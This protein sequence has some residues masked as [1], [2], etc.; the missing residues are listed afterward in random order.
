MKDKVISTIVLT[1][2]EEQNI[3]YCLESLRGSTEIF[4]VDSGS[5]DRTI[6]I[7][8]QFN[9]Q[10]FH[11]SYTNHASQWQWAFDNLPISTP[12]ILALDADFVVSPVLLEKIIRETGKVPDDVDGIYVRHLYKFGWGTI[13]FGGTKKHWLRI[14]RR[15]RARADRG[16]LVDFRF[17]VDGRVLVWHEMVV[18]YNR[19]DDDISVWLGKQDKFALR[20]A[21]EE[22]L[23]RRGLH[24]WEGRP[25]LIGTTDERFAWL[26]DR[27]LGLPLFVR[28]IIYFL[29][30]YVIAAGALDGRAGFLYHVL[31]GFW[32]RLIVDWKTV[33]LRSLDLDDE[34]LQ[35]FGRAMLK[36]H[37]GSVIEVQR[38][39]QTSLSCIEGWSAV[40]KTSS[41]RG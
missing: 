17:V 16:D 35:S 10:I 2:N 23:R 24:G 9:V 34:Q 33:Q 20:L 41:Q 15:G 1:H 18:E 32:L 38:S 26:R 4:V 36:T 7:C 12:W 6:D 40:A 37:S 29:Y 13:R 39:I 22:E 11:H 19:K 31:Q 28:P 21:V 3:G 14:V 27:W 5:T 8:K 30:R 25:R